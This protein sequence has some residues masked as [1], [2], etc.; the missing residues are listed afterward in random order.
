M[1]IG[2][3]GT[4]YPIDAGNGECGTG[5]GRAG[6][7]RTP[8]LSDSDNF[9]KINEL[10]LFKGPKEQ[11]VYKAE[12]VGVKTREELIRDYGYPA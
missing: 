9:S 2:V 1:K 7:P 5:R 6:A 3:V 10:W 4:T 12:F 11:K 8:V